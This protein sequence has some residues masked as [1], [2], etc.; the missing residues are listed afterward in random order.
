MAQLKEAQ[1]A[2]PQQV[3]VQNHKIQVM[4]KGDEIDTFVKKLQVAMRA[5]RIPVDKWKQSLLPQMTLEATEEVVHLLENNDSQYEDIKAALLDSSAMTFVAAAEC[6]FTAD[7][8]TITHLPI[9]RVVDNITRWLEKMTEG[10][11]TLRLAIDRMVVGVI[12]CQ[13]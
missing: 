3:M 5:A 1:P 4:T 10:T 2:G 12:W 9:R 11:E 6:L 13:N 7:K 8:G